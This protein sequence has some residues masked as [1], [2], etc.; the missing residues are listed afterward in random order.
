M[1]KVLDGLYRFS[2]GMAALS[3]VGIVVIVFGQVV[4]NV[5]DFVALSL[6]N[7]SFG[8][9][10]P[11]YASL[12]GYALGF[13]T[14]LSLGLGFRQTTHIRV[15]LLESKLAAP[16]RR[17]TLTIIALIGVVMGALFTYGLGQLAYQS[18]M[19]G[20]RASGLLRVPLWIPQAVLCV[21]AGV[22]L[23]AAIDT[24]VDMLRQGRSEAL[25]IESAAEEAL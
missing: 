1:R 3:L 14:F 19:W 25:R 15:T 12:S 13:A 23:I 7:K 24:L 6:F 2:G 21:G 8:L 9:L 4:L 18:L 16:V 5:V 11:S 20:D 10:I 17:S 22:F